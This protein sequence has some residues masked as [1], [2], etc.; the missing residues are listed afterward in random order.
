[1]APQSYQFVMRTGPNPGKSFPLTNDELSIGRD[2]SN[3][4]VI[5][6]AEVS[7]HHARLYRQAG[8]FVLEDTGST[9]GTFVNGQRLMGPHM[10]RPGEMILLGENISLIFEA[11]QFDPD[12]TIA[13]GTVP[14]MPSYQQQPAPSASYP[15]PQP[16]YGQTP[17]PTQDPSAP[18]YAGAVPAQVVLACGVFGHL[19]ARDIESTSAWLPRLCD[20]GA[21]VI[22]TR[23]RRDPDRAPWMRGLFA[24]A[25]FSEID[26]ASPS[27]RMFCVGTHRL[28]RE[29]LAFE[30]GQRVFRFVGDG[31]Q[32][33]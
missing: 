7:R 26:F 24:A 11:Y 8:G 33:A 28:D 9:N 29:P 16:A 2:I 21:H 5:N 10:L 15:A 20:R 30:P 22:G 27:D 14:D 6:D 23:H 13:S 3:D 12:A 4:I 19:S 32:P 25:G 1:M 18:A 17:S 31:E